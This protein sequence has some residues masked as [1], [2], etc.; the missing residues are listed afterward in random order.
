MINDGIDEPFIDDPPLDDDFELPE[1]VNEEILPKKARPKK[2]ALD[3]DDLPG[4]S[5][6]YEK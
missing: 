3:L 4:P 5:K 2:S 1:P 6:M